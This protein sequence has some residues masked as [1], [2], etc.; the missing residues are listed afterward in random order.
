MKLVKPG[1]QK[2]IIVL[3]ILTIS[4]INLQSVSAYPCKCHQDRTLKLCRPYMKGSDVLAVQQQLQRLGFYS[5]NLDGIYGNK[6]AQSVAE[7]QKTYYINDSGIVNQ[8]TW[9]LLG[10]AANTLAV[11]SRNEKPEGKLT[12]TINLYQRTLI[13]YEDGE[14]YKIYPVAIGK[15]EEPSPVGEWKIINKYERIVEGP[16]GTRWMGLNVP[17]GVYGIH[18]TNKPWQ[19]G[20]AASS[21]CIRMHNQY[22]EELFEWVPVETPVNIIGKKPEIILNKI[23]KPGQ[24]GKIVMKLQEELRQAE[25]YPGYLDA[26]YGELTANAVRELET[27]FGLKV[28]GIADLNLIKLL[29]QINSK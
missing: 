7:L 12:I 24:K 19:I 6:T 25:Y 21:G 22:V 1:I 11:N 8:Q 29:K 27:Q 28:D 14:A 10:K 18:G 15:K 23:I 4:F 26:S 16:L 2:L 5:G 3:S 9:N 20:T 13:L 17:W